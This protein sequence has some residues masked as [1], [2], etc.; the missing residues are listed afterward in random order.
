M[1]F[2]LFLNSVISIHS[3]Y[4]GRDVCQEPT[5]DTFQNFNPLSLY[6]ERL[7]ML[8]YVLNRNVI[9]IHSPYTG[10]DAQL[11]ESNSIIANF[12]PLSLY[13]ERRC[14]W[15][16]IIWLKKFQSTLPIQGET[17]NS[18]IFTMIVKR[19]QSTLPIQGE[20]W[21]NAQFTTVTIIS[22]HSPYTGRDN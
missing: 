9:S 19:F 6:R 3:P 4:T 14:V 20:T 18:C 1:I 17:T 12:N 11:Q 7:V 5:I 16:V 22:I 2:Y 15:E 21:Y 10:R 8:F 13:R